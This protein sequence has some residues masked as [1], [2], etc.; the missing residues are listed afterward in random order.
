MKTQ[1][2]WMRVVL[3]NLLLMRSP[4]RSLQAYMVAMLSIT[5]GLG[6]WA[7]VSNMLTSPRD[8]AVSPNQLSGVWRPSAIEMY[9]LPDECE[10]AGLHHGTEDV[11]PPAIVRVIKPPAQQQQLVDCQVEEE[12]R[13]EEIQREAPGR[14]GIKTLE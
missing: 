7:A 12:I 9:L 14:D 10:E 1:R 3:A 8:T 2:W 11:G 13:G 4:V 5:C 6:A